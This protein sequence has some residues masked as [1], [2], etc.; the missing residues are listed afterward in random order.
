M[1]EEMKAVH[2][3]HKKMGV[4][5]CQLMKAT[6]WPDIKIMGKQL[7]QW[8]A[9]MEKK[10]ADNRHDLRLLRAHLM[11][12]ELGEVLIAMGEGNELDTLDGLTDLL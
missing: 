2:E 3:F 8:S 7:L 1:I 10:L 6:E 9:I 4:S 5:P 12:E 11:L